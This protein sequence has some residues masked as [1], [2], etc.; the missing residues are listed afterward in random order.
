M[1][2]LK[3]LAGRSKVMAEA[4]EAHHATTRTPGHSHRHIAHWKGE[5]GGGGTGGRLNA[6]GR[7]GTRCLRWTG[8]PGGGE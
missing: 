1:K 7:Q 2:H 6:W 3:E 8:P 5:G 4:V